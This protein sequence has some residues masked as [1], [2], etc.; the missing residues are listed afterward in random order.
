MKS[1]VKNIG[2]EGEENQ[3][4]QKNCR[5]RIEDC[6]IKKII[7]LTTFGIGALH[8]SANTQPEKKKNAD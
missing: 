7:P 2:C 3:E 1:T 5:M 4:I 6:G 8:S